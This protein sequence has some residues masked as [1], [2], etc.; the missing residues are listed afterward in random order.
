M[1]TR[2][3]YQAKLEG[4]KPLAIGYK[5]FLK[6]WSTKYGNYKYATPNGKAIGTVHTV[7]GILEECRNG[8]HFCK[9]PEDCFIFYK[10]YTYYRFAQVEAY[11]ELKN[12]DDKKSIART[13][14]IVKE[15]SYE[16]FLDLCQDEEKKRGNLCNENICHS[17][18]IIN[19]AYIK[20]SKHVSQSQFIEESNYVRY[21]YQVQYSAVINESKQINDCHKIHS[22]DLCYSSSDIYLSKLVKHSHHVAYGTNISDSRYVYNSRNIDNCYGIKDCTNIEDGIFCYNIHNN[23]LMLFNKPVT[24]ERFAEVKF[25]LI[26]FYQKIEFS[27]MQDLYT[28]AFNKKGSEYN[29]P[30]NLDDSTLKENPWKNID[31]DLLMY[32]KELPEF[33]AVIFKQI[34]GV[35]NE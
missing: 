27:N 7:T 30:I 19:S 15:Y 21:S 35:Y 34:T 18:G 29:L 20:D 33:D 17:Y 6:D 25:R 31:T 4:K 1:S 26:D 12:V 5:V 13:L 9:K 2:R 11:D 28:E 10:P 24:R 3:I 32:I 16:E 23:S 8:L 22:S 14:K